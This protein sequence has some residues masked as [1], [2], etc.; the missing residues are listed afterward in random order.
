ML[1]GEITGLVGLEVVEDVEVEGLVDELD[2]L[3]GVNE[4]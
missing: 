3:E 2:M 1:P 4:D